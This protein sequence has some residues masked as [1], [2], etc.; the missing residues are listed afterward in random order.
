MSIQKIYQQKKSEIRSRLDEFKSL[1]E[2]ECLKEHIFCLLTPQSQ[3]KKCWQAVEEIF[4]L[5]ERELTKKN[6]VKILSTKTRFH[7][8]KSGRV[9]AALQNWGNTKTIL[10]EQNSF[11]LRNQLAEKINGYWLKEASH[12]LRNVGR[13]DNQIAILDRHILRN[14][15]ALNLIRETKVNSKKDYLQIEKIFISFASNQ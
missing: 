3:A 2:K 9:L 4:A 5:P 15:R 14:L 11:E 12:F 6:L 7:H 1:P 13:S 10:Q 8:T